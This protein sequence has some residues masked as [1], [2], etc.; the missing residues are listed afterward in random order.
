MPESVCDNVTRRAD[1]LLCRLN[2]GLE[3]GGA[4]STGGRDDMCVQ[5]YSLKKEENRNSKE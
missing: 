2:Q 3:M 1:L 5:N 4:C